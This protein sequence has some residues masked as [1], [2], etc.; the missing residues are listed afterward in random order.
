MSAGAGTP[1]ERRMA[2]VAQS[3]E[4]RAAMGAAFDD[5]ERRFAVAERVVSV[6]R[7]I[8]RHRAAVGAAALFTVFAPRSARTWVRRAF[9]LLPLVIAG[10]R[11]V[12]SLRPADPPNPS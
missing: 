3:Q 10:Y 12:R 6:A 7:G 4:N 1:S 11:L 2:L 9:A 5:L 8:G